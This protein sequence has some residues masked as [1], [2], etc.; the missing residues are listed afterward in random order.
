MKNLKLD[1][2]CIIY[3]RVSSSKQAQQGESLSEQEKICRA[4]A[5]RDN[6]NVVKVFREQ[7]S[8]RSEDRPVI[9]EIFSFIKKNPR[10]I[11]TL[12]V[13]SLDRFSRGGTS[14]YEN[15]KEKLANKGIKLIDS[16]G[17][18]QESKNTLAHLGLEY[19]WS[20]LYPSEVSEL[21]MSYQSKNEVNQIL[22][23]MISSEVNLVRGGYKV[24][25]AN[26][27]YKNKKVFI[28]GAKKKT[29]Q[30]PD[31]ERAPFFIKMFEMSITHSDKEVVD[32]VN[33]MGYRSKPRKKWSKSKDKILGTTKGI[34][35]TV[36]QL[37]KIRQRP[38]YAGVNDEK[39][40]EEPIKTQYEGL[41]SIKK[42]NQANKGKV[43]IEEC[44]DGRIKI[45]KDYNPHQLKRMKD[46]LVFPHKAVILC[47]EC[48]KPFLGSS[49][50]SKSGKGV[51]IYHCCRDHKYFG[52]NKKELEKHLTSFVTELKY[53]KEFM[54][55]FKATLMNKYRE[56]EKEL[57]EF[58]VQVSKSVIDLETQKQQKIEVYTSTQ[59]E[60][61]RAEL[62][63]QID[64]LHDEI[65]K[66]RSERNNIEVQ[67]DDINAF[68]RYVKVLME[69]PVEMLVKQE[70]ITSLKAL[71]GLV[72]DELP[73]YHQLL[74]GTPKLSL[75]YKLSE[76][77]VDDK[78]LNVMTY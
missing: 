34:Q 78:S 54:K 7:F 52:V 40:L 55:S 8:G 70:N 41:V 36:K 38:I 3:C 6:L 48:K 22:T 73:T 60:I 4:I 23:R 65:E 16:H 42:W 1:K 74:N 46:N 61:I 26:D 25:D 66:I 11:D 33:A 43:F 58:S 49:P 21:V 9:E 44:T 28:D 19:P 35:L 62:E 71:F 31:P 47:P 12:L 29:I 77:F 32:Y 17:M 10:K 56:K 72:F 37:Q 59:N 13:R 15:L 18:I 30:V 50:K 67:E 51:P 45:H 57:G 20:I 64:G 24:R 63:K 2:N 76:D 69:H 75:P 27:G 39:W 68:V 14:S 53:K 5:Q